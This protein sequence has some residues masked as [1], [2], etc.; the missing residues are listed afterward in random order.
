MALN[1]VFLTATALFIIA[2]LKQ[3]LEANAF[4]N[5]LREHH[6]DQYE[7]MGKPRWN[8]QFGDNRFRD[9][10]KYIRH[11]K[12]I[13]LNDP[14]LARIHKAIKKADYVAF[15]AAVTAILVTLFQV[16]QTTY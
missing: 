15:A 2:I 4:L 10:V 3:L 6:P 13:E 8:I 14:E 9:A 16:M 12:F 5:R 1:F 7:A 11:K